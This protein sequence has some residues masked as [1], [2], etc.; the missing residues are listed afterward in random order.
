MHTSSPIR[1]AAGEPGRRATA[2]RADRDGFRP[3]ALPALAAA[4]RVGAQG[5]ARTAQTE[6]RGAAARRFL[7][8]DAVTEDETSA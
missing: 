7:H 8:E 2:S 4:V 5:P 6:R 1:D 3:L